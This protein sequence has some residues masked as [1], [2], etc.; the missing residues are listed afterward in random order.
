[1]QVQ[2]ILKTL[3]LALITCTNYYTRLKYCRY[4]FARYCINA[5]KKNIKRIFLVFLTVAVFNLL[6]ACA[7]V[8]AILWLPKTIFNFTKKGM[9][10]A[11]ENIF[12]KKKFAQ[13]DVDLGPRRKPSSNPGVGVQPVMPQDM[14][15]Y[16]A[17]GNYPY[18]PMQGQAMPYGAGQMPPSAPAYQNGNGYTPPNNNM[19]MMPPS[20][21]SQQG[22]APIP[23]MPAQAP[24]SGYYPPMQ[25]P[26]MGGQYPAYPSMPPPAGAYGGGS[27]YPMPP[28]S[29][30]GNN[31]DP[32]DPFSMP[33]HKLIAKFEPM[34]YEGE[35]A[36]PVDL[37]GYMADEPVKKHKNKSMF[38][39][40][41]YAP[42]SD[43]P[44]VQASEFPKLG[45]MPKSP[46]AENDKKRM[47][48]QIDNLLNELDRNNKQREDIYKGDDADSKAIN[49]DIDSEV[50]QDKKLLKRVK[51]KNND[52]KTFMEK[53][54]GEDK[55]KDS[56]TDNIT[57]N[58]IP[59]L[60]PISVPDLPVV[61]R[62]GY[63]I[64]SETPIPP[65]VVVPRI[66][67]ETPAAERPI[68]AG[69]AYPGIL[70]ESRYSGKRRSSRLIEEN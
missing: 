51:P 67:P 15:G 25:P 42:K 40:K 28:A 17:G 21:Q 19:R 14:S 34:A 52:K 20:P 1:M 8:D 7:V 61:D 5:M 9:D 27:G 39:F 58:E 30:Y 12:N 68:R 55:K 59:K 69:G 26:A 36:E 63:D 66:T 45:A 18:P 60:P 33:R 62:R 70:P 41:E 48:N 65:P 29:P 38:P 24:S 56:G 10:T 6:S 13:D 44:I 3:A 4:I 47:G 32:I 31:D 22:F 46:N 2:V 43:V 57:V 11:E 23:P 50:I 37:Q 54:E 53:K 64:E 35:E 16:R 49:G